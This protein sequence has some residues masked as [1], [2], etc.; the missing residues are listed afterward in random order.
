M[1]V[2]LRLSFRHGFAV[3][4]PSQREALAKTARR[5]ESLSSLA[6]G[7]EQGDGLYVDGAGEHVDRFGFF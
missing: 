1:P 3:P 5:V 7:E 4:P 2:L 6:I